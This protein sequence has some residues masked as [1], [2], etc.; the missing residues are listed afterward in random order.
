MKLFVAMPCYGGFMHAKCAISMM[1][2]YH[3]CTQEGIPMYM[4]TTLNDSLITRARNLLVDAFLKSD[5][6]HL[7][8]VD[9]D[10][11]FSVDDMMKMLKTDVDLI[12]GL[13]AKKSIDWGNIERCVQKG[14]AAQDLPYNATTAVFIRSVDDSPLDPQQ[15]RRVKWVGTGLML[16]KRAVF[17]RMREEYPGETYDQQ[18]IPDIYCYFDGRIMQGVAT[19]GQRRVN[20]YLSEDWYFCERWT[21]MG[22]EIYAAL[23]MRSTHYGQYGFLVDATRYHDSVAMLN[24]T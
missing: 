11:E 3:R 18:G 8:F 1:S 23:W 2:L 16:V 4:H 6:T 24:L 22:G 15:A 14:C 21:R 5:A 19:E 9:A 13:Y 10:I 7:L 17:E 20:Q 12:G